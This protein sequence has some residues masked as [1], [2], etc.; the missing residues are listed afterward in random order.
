MTNQLSGKCD[1]ITYEL[2]MYVIFLEIKH[3]VSPACYHL[4]SELYIMTP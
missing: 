3:F 4:S 2:I 1:Y